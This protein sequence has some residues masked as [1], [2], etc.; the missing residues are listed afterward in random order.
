MMKLA[1]LALSGL[2]LLSAC[3]SPQSATQGTPTP[4]A[5]TSPSSYRRDP[6]TGLAANPA[7]GK[8]PIKLV[9]SWEPMVGPQLLKKPGYEILT[10]LTPAEPSHT[11]KSIDFLIFLPPKSVALGAPFPIPSDSIPVGSTWTIP[12]SAAAHFLKQLHPSATAD[13]V[14]DGPGAYGVLRA[15]SKERWEIDFRIHAQFE[16]AKGVFVT[17]AQF[18]GRMIVNL[19]QNK[20]EYVEFTVPQERCANVAIDCVVGEHLAGVGRIP[21]MQLVGGDEKLLSSESW[22]RQISLE[23]AH[24]LLRRQFYAFEAIDW[25]PP[26]VALARASIEHKPLLAIVIAGPLDDQSC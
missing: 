16:V 6:K 26:K 3:G 4:V 1:I 12:A 13:L 7:L 15:S 19:P 2:I 25:S 23:E 22:L 24:R 14:F 17:P 5:S 21:R 8:S 9:A 20:V 11:Y 18:A 10:K